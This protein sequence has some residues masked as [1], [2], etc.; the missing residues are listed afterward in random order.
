MSMIDK[1]KQKLKGHEKHVSQAVDK[2]GDLVDRK[3][4]GKYRKH[5]DTAQAKVKEQLGKDGGKDGGMGGGGATP[6]R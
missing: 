2:A 4:H 1:L 5:V 3:T 6:P